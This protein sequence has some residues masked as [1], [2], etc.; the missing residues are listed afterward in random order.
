MAG[1]CAP[2][3]ALQDR[4]RVE[5]VQ[6]RAFEGAEDVCPEA[7]D[8]EAA[9]DGVEELELL[10]GPEEEHGAPGV[11]ELLLELVEDP[12]VERLQEVRG[13][14]HERDDVDLVLQQQ[15]HHLGLLHE[16]VLVHE[17]HAPLLL[18]ALSQAPP[19]RLELR[20]QPALQQRRE[21][22]LVEPRLRVA[23]VAVRADD[24]GVL[25]QLLGE[26]LRG[27]NE[28]GL[29]PGAVGEHGERDGEAEDGVLGE[30]VR[31]LHATRD[32][33]GGLVGPDFEEELV[34]VADEARGVVAEL[35]L[36]LD[37]AE[38]L[39]E[40]EA[41][42]FEGGLIDGV[43]GDGFDGAAGDDA[44][45][46]VALQLIL[47][48]RFL[49]GGHPAGS[50]LALRDAARFDGRKRAVEAALG[51][52]GEGDG[53]LVGEA[54]VDEEHGD[55]DRHGALEDGLQFQDRLAAGRRRKQVG[56][57]L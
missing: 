57:E 29:H 55:G 2:I 25:P 22:R 32:E 4:G 43:E 31:W 34:E 16:R 33:D 30:L 3:R 7:R 27:E 20:D 6:P 19:P 1:G 8:G 18:E 40:G 52:A 42:G 17:Q 12:H 13:V 35:E 14:G 50:A 48:A 15:V 47:E 44:V 26:Q 23:L 56:R 21:R 11:V 49:L 38:E 5:R 9:V 36:E 24:V 46:E 54:V 10:G 39:L 37:E 51:A 45:E 28:A 53:D 41:E